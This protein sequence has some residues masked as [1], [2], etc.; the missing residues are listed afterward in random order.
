MTMGEFMRWLATA[1]TLF[2][3]LPAIAG[4]NDPRLAALFERL[5]V[6]DD[7]REGALLQSVIWSLWMRSGDP[8][9]DA[10]MARGIAAMEG[11]DLAAAEAAFTEIVEKRPD[12]AEGW[13]KRATVRYLARNFLGS[14]A[15]IEQTLKLEPRHFGALSG[16]GLVYLAMGRDEAALEAFKRAHALAPHLPGGDEQIRELEG[17]IKGR[18]I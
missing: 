7:A 1:A 11:R 3:S 5:A 6:T 18:R 16:L 12:F 14:I 10:L 2:V 17:R 15:D 13:N 9:I 4:Q 8:K